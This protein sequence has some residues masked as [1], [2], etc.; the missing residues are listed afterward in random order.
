MRSYKIFFILFL[1]FAPFFNANGAVKL[2]T[3]YDLD[4]K[5]LNSEEKDKL[6]NI[7]YT[8]TVGM[9]NQYKG[10]LKYTE[11]KED[12]YLKDVR[13]YFGLGGR[14][15]MA[16]D[17]KLEP[18]DNT[19][20]DTAKI[21]INFKTNFNYF[22]SGGLYW[23]NGIRTEFEY[24]EATLKADAV[25]GNFITKNKNGTYSNINDMTVKFLIK[26]YMINFIFENVNIKSPIKPYFG[27]G[28]GMVSGDMRNLV[29]TAKSNVF[30]GQVM[31]GLSYPISDGIVAIYLGYRGV[32]ASEMEQDFIKYES[33]GLGG[34]NEVNVKEKYKY[35][36][37][38]VDLGV[39]FFF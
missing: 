38:N 13:A 1:C 23:R 28:A 5:Q 20:S 24:S 7:N 27:F 9:P 14:F 12:V 10:K 33:D 26:T 35:Q 15:T 31:A 21:D 34:Y 2:S 6:K 32:F 25:G 37:N 18:Q 3:P 4:I 22:A 8:Q 30:G 17:T 11:G 29:N 19:Y 16:K 36:S 39:K